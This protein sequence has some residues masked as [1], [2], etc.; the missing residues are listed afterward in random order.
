MIEL[1]LTISGTIMAMLLSIIGYFLKVLH[2]DVRNLNVNLMEFG[3]RLSVL[4]SHTP[5]TD[6]HHEQRLDN[7]EKRL[8]SHSQRIRNLENRKNESTRNNH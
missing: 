8:E 4:E 6:S 5:Q 2:E 1:I 3:R 7:H